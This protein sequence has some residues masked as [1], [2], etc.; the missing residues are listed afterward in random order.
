MKRFNPPTIWE[1]NRR[2]DL[3]DRSA[4]AVGER[5][6][7]ATCGL[8]PHTLPNTCRACSNELREARKTNAGQRRPRPLAA[9]RP[10]LKP[11]SCLHP[12]HSCIK[13]VAF[14]TACL[15]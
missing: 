5:L 13:A 9:P 4:N 10:G 1:P 12:F 6:Q 14:G 11:I 15:R 8:I 7:G 2:Q 3:P